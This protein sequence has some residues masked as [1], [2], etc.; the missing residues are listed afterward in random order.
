MLKSSDDVHQQENYNYLDFELEQEDLDK[1]D[2][3]DQG[4][5][6]RVEGQNPRE[7]EEFV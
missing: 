5:S 1:I 4:E 3:L 2:A 7:Y 6:G